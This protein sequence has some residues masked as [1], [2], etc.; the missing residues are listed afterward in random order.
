MARPHGRELR[1]VCEAFRSALREHVPLTRLRLD[2]ALAE[3]RTESY[4]FVDPEPVPRPN[5]DGT[6]PIRPLQWRTAVIVSMSDG[7]G[8][9]GTVTVEHASREL[10]ADELQ[11]EIERVA[12]IYAPA[13]RA[14]ARGKGDWAP[15]LPGRGARAPRRGRARK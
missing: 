11:G 6:M 9:L 7:D 1:G 5:D 12:R 2:L 8:A 4:V 3:G 10:S 13:L 14:C 15:V